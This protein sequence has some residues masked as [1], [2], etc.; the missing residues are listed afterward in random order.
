MGGY[1]WRIL[2]YPSGYDDEHDGHETVLLQLQV[3]TTPMDP[4]VVLELEASG[5]IAI[6]DGSRSVSESEDEN[7]FCSMANFCHRYTNDEPAEGCRNLTV[8]CLVGPDDSLTVECSFEFQVVAN[9]TTTTP[10]SNLVNVHSIGIQ[11][12]I[13]TCAFCSRTV[14][15]KDGALP[16]C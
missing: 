9:K 10:K 14:Q 12:T 8:S 15:V 11:R 4:D 13:L 1:E 7:D 16:A 5:S 2:Y 6:G 3:A